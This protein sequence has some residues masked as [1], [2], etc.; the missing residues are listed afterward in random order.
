MCRCPVVYLH[1]YFYIP[2]RLYRPYYYTIKRILITHIFNATTLFLQQ[3]F[4]KR[5]GLTKHQIINKRFFYF[6]IF[7]LV[8]QFTRNRHP[9]LLAPHTAAQKKLYINRLHFDNEIQ[10]RGANFPSFFYSTITLLKAIIFLLFL[11][12]F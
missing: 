10:K 6:P 9:S 4:I 5:R 2:L 3:L 12:F 1:L 7:L 8:S 11:Q